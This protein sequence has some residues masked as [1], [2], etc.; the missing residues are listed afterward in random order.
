VRVQASRKTNQTLG[1]AG[2]DAPVARG[3]GVGKRIARNGAPDPQVIELGGLGAQAL[4]NIAQALPIRQLRKGHERVLIETGESLDHVLADVMRHAAAESGV[5]QMA[6]QLQTRADLDASS[7]SAA[8]TAVTVR[9]TARIDV[10][11]ETSRQRHFM[12]Y[13]Q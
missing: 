1:E 6:H 9:A 5:R 7:H 10:Q 8:R 2:V 11:I 13:V 12:Q 3:I 4:L